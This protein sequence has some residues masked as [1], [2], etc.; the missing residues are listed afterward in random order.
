MLNIRHQWAVLGLLISPLA[1]GQNPGY[2]M[3][4]TQVLAMHNTAQDQTYELYIKLPE[5]YHRASEQRYPVIYFTDAVWH[6]EVLSAATSSLYE[7]VILVGI[8]WQQNVDASL[9]SEVGPHVSRFSDYSIRPAKDPDRQAKYRFGQAKQHL[10][11]IRDQ[12]IPYVEQN[13]R[14]D[15]QQR[16]YFGYSLGGLFGA[17]VLAA[18]P[19]LFKNFIIGSP[20]LQND[21]AFLAEMPLPQETGPAH[22][23]LSRGSEEQDRAA[24]IDTFSHNMQKRQA[25]I[26][27]TSVVIEG[28]H[29]TAFPATAIQAI[30]WLAQLSTIGDPS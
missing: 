22:V 23:F 11:F 26:S 3:P 8:S 21:N 28:N 15:P 30:A 18:Q 12:V 5:D 10:S 4:N 2:V 17:Y 19:E 13:F 20:S 24:F 16:T 29:Q 6:I 27:I 7:G 9:L 1:L 14:A 25:D